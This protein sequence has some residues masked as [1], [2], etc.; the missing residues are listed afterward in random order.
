[1]PTKLNNLNLWFSAF[2]LPGFEMFGG[3]TVL[4]RSE[5]KFTQSLKSL[6]GRLKTSLSSI[7]L[8]LIVDI[9]QQRQF[10]D[11]L[12]GLVYI[13]CRTKAPFVLGKHV[14]LLVSCCVSLE[15]FKSFMICTSCPNDRCFISDN[16]LAGTV[17]IS[18]TQGTRPSLTPCTLTQK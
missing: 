18:I 5:Q 15:L 10:W 9:S 8:M 11:G 7:W 2:L 3:T 1:M 17:F 16:S 6:V 14:I 4:Y 13:L 12:S